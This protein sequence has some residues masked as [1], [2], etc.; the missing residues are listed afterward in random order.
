MYVSDV[1]DV[2]MGEWNQ[3]CAVEGERIEEAHISSTE[4][5]HRRRVEG[6]QYYD[7]DIM[8]SLR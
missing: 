4:L 1:G 6:V 8:N 5:V 2:Y 3:D 7:I